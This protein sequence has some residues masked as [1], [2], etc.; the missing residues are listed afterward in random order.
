M[1]WLHIQKKCDVY[2]ENCLKLV[3]QLVLLILCAFTIKKLKE[4]GFYEKTHFACFHLGLILTSA[5][6]VLISFH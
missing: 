1:Q 6:M 2:W 3:F 4:I 5:Y